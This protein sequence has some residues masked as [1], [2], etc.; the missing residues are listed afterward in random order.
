MI[1]NRAAH[2][3]KLSKTALLVLGVFTLALG[4]GSMILA[5]H[6]PF[7]QDRITQSLQEDFPVTVTFQKFHS[8]YFPH[9]GC[10]GEGLVFR[11]LGSSP[12][13]PPIVTIQRFTIE[14]HYTDLL[15]RPGYL[16]SIVMNGFRVHVP[17]SGTTLEQSSWKETKSTARV[18]EIVADGAAVEIARADAN[19]P[20][21][22]TS[23]L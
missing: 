8:A 15:L 7:S 9:P 21:A 11:R 10:V 16:A 17:P 22:S 13:T 1:Q 23:T 14:A 19:A 5:L 6:W 3:T 12:D 4:I 20:C 2:I 18:G